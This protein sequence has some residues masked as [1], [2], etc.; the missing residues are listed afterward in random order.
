M[1]ILSATLMCLTACLLAFSLAWADGGTEFSGTVLTVDQ[2]T[3]K[4]AVKKESG[5]TRFMFTAN[6]KTV[7]Q[8]AG[9]SSLTDLKKDDKVVVLYHVQG[10]QYLALKVTKQK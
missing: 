8:G 10:P 9:L 2:A 4:F 3:G 7:F 6:D 5:G 1:P